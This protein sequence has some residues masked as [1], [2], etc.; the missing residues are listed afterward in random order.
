MFIS[1]FEQ[2]LASRRRVGYVQ[3]HQNSQ[4]THIYS[5]KTVHLT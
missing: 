2:F 5:E 1:N 3:L 4:Y